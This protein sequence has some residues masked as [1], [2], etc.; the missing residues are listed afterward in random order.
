M[1]AVSGRITSYNV[2]YTKLLRNNDSVLVAGAI[3]T[4]SVQVTDGNQV[5]IDTLEWRDITSVIRREADGQWRVVR[6]TSTLPFANQANDTPPAALAAPEAGKP[7]GRVRVGELRIT[8]NSAIL[9]SD[10]NNFV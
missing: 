3:S 2:C 9:F 6:I 10:R 5:S 4:N 8:G 7:A 1:P